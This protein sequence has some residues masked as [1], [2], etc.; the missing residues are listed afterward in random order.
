MV[1][2]TRRLTAKGNDEEEEV[3]FSCGGLP[4]S[5]R[6]HSVRIICYIRSCCLHRQAK[7]SYLKMTVLKFS[8]ICGVQQNTYRQMKDGPSENFVSY[9]QMFRPLCCDI[10]INTCT[11]DKC[12]KHQAPLLNNPSLHVR[13]SKVLTKL[14]AGLYIVKG[15]TLCFSAHIMIYICIYIYIY[16]C[17]HNSVVGRSLHCL[18]K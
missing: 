11:I 6:S 14:C 3:L 5:A 10:K 9:G 17:I 7:L 8:K 1:V 4:C 18:N 12:G 2:G 16:V 13:N 15:L